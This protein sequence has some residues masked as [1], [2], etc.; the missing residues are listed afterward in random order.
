MGHVADDNAKDTRDNPDQFDHIDGT[1]Q[2][3][4]LGKYMDMDQE[5]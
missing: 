2:G 3:Q 5:E 4:I 1:D